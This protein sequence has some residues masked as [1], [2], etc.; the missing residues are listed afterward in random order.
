MIRRRWRR[1]YD[2]AVTVKDKGRRRATYTL[3][4]LREDWLL[5]NK[6]HGFRTLADSGKDAL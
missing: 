1:I 2:H 6:G 5:L 3:V 4:P